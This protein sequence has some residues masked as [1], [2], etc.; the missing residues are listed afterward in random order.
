[1]FLSSLIRRQILYAMCP[2]YNVTHEKAY[3]LVEIRDRP[4]RFHQL[5]GK[6]VGQQRYRYIARF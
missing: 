4:R 3:R 6:K 2:C 1:M 5:R